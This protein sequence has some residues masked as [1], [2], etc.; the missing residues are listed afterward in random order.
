MMVRQSDE[1]EVI[2]KIYEMDNIS[3]EYDFSMIKPL[4]DLINGVIIK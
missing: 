3:K 2:Q 1:F 4:Y